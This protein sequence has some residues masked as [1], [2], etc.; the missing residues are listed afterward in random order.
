[1]AST[2]TIAVPATANQPSKG[3]NRNMTATQSGAQGRSNSALV[4]R[5]RQQ[6]L[7]RRK[8]PQRPGGPVPQL[9][10]L[11]LAQYHAEHPLI[12]C[13]LKLRPDARQ[14][15]PAYMVEN[16]HEPEQEHHDDEQHYQRVHG[17]ARQH[18]A[19]DLQHEQRPGEHQDVHDTGE[20]SPPH[21][22]RPAPAP[23]PAATRS[24]GQGRGHRGEGGN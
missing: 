14:H 15:A 2:S 12:E 9:W 3:W 23:E 21:T 16:T 10:H 8:V 7:D 6:R 1:M 22:A 4:G 5:I 11:R 17:K 13:G 19:I 24:P 20:Q 18:P